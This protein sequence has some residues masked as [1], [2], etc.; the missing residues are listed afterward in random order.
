MRVALC[1]SG[2]LRRVLEFFPI[3]RNNILEPYDPDVFI[4]TWDMPPN[5]AT[6]VANTV[7]DPQEISTISTVCKLYNPDGLYVQQYS[8]EIKQYLTGL[9]ETRNDNLL[10]MAFHIMK[11]IRLSQ[12]RASLT[13]KPYDIVIRHRFDYGVKDIQF[14]NHD[15]NAINI[16]SEH[17]YGG[18]QD[19]FAFGRPHVM[20]IYADWRL[21][22]VQIEN[23]FARQTGLPTNE[24]DCAGFP[25]Q[26]EAALKRYL[27]C[28]QAPVC[29][30][31]GL[32]IRYP[33]C[34][35]KEIGELYD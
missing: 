8:D 23:A 31:D 17:D 6:S 34:T 7:R 26:P 28:T 32:S 9:G 1:L 25:W 10:S 11:S 21:H 3:I 2:E 15:L 33:W 19:Q 22:V 18:Y 16:P 30:M 29:L 4:S 14:E 20:E 27:D 5:I 35:I 13:N 12:E 24:N